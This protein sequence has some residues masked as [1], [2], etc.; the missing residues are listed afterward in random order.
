MKDK[1]SKLCR[2]LEKCKY[3]DTCFRAHSKDEYTPVECRFKNCY[4]LDCKFYHPSRETKDEYI[5][6]CLI[7][8]QNV[9]RHTKFC[10]KMKEDFPC[11]KKSCPFAHSIDDIILP[12]GYEQGHKI[13]EAE[14]V[15]GIKIQPFMCNPSW[16]NHNEDK[17]ESNV[18]KVVE[19]VENVYN[20]EDDEKKVEDEMFEFLISLC[21]NKNKSKRND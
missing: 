14:R 1:L 9:K 2:Y 19:N 13:E 7:F 20:I 4:N 8:N 12:Y 17:E 15:F 18:E 16:M 10:R 21:K 3:I 6:K 5:E 11:T